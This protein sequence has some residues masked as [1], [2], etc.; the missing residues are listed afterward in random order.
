MYLSILERLLGG[1]LGATGRI[2]QRKHDGTLVE[3]GHVLQDLRREEIGRRRG[4]N[5][6]LRRRVR[7][8]GSEWKSVYNVRESSCVASS[9]LTE[10]LIFLTISPRSVMAGTSLAYAALCPSRLPVGRTFVS[11]PSTSHIQI[12]LRAS[13]IPKA[14]TET[15]IQSNVQSHL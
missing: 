11:R 13:Y 12:L 1:A 5:Q 3:L 8:I 10:G 7:A 4:A 9:S 2:R 15:L 14:Q 6:D